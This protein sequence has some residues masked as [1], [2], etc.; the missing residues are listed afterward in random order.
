LPFLSCHYQFELTL[1]PKLLLAKVRQKLDPHIPSGFRI[2]EPGVGGMTQMRSFFSRGQPAVHDPGHGIECKFKPPPY[3]SS[4]IEEL[5]FLSPFCYSYSRTSTYYPAKAAPHS[6]GTLK[7]GQLLKYIV[8]T[9]IK[10]DP[11]SMSF[12]R[13]QQTSQ[14]PRSSCSLNRHPM[15]CP[16]ELQQ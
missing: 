16:V 11:S 6:R 14:V 15:T 10:A 2:V 4:T 1:S 7:K 13:C 5:R 8:K 9:M 3:D 12:L